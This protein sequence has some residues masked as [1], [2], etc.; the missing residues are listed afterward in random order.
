MT[1]TATMERRT[2][3]NAVLTRESYT[4]RTK[5][6]SKTA[7]KKAKESEKMAGSQGSSK[8]QEEELLQGKI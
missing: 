5:S 7:S 3:R 8:K 1:T 4:V 6:P 2:E